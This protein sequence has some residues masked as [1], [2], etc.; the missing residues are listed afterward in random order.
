MYVCITENIWLLHNAGYIISGNNFQIIMREIITNI[1]FAMRPK[2]K[3][4]N[5]RADIK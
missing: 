4:I 5:E 2:Y 1:I 3:Y